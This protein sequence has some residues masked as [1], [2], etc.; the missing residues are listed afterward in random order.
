[1]THEEITQCVTDG[2]RAALSDPRIHCRYHVPPED[3]DAQHEAMKRFIRFTGRLEDM[4]WKAVGKFFAAFVIFLFG[5]MAYGA[6]IKL[7]ILLGLG[8]AGR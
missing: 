8:L 2:I 3:H 4:K 6:A 7:K 1:M 5:L